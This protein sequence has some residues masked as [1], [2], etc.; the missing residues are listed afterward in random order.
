MNK[1]TLFFTIITALSNNCLVY[2]I[3]D[4]V[5]KYSV[6]LVKKRLARNELLDF[7]GNTDETRK[8]GIL[9]RL[10]VDSNSTLKTGVYNAPRVD[11]NKTNEF[12]LA[13][14]GNSGLNVSD[15]SPNLPQ[16]NVS[17]G[18]RTDNSSN[19]IRRNKKSDV[20]EPAKTSLARNDTDSNTNSTG[21]NTPSEKDLQMRDYAQNS[22]EF[23]DIFNA[24]K[25]TNWTVYNGDYYIME[26]SDYNTSVPIV[27]LINLSV[28]LYNKNADPNLAKGLISS[29]FGTRTFGELDSDN[30][31]DLDTD[32][33]EGNTGNGIFN[34]DNF[35]NWDDFD[36]MDEMP[37]LFRSLNNIIWL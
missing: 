31:T 28:G 33:N 18:E 23:I 12:G 24:I 35:I 20:P 11:N 22:D 29:I 26:F 21:V 13:D 32:Y 8:L 5:D 14:F 7:H 34:L 25:D 3:K 36:I 4:G 9:R 16:L 10:S 2:T 19:N 30:T 15:Q 17:H 37:A 1:L 6:K 27:K